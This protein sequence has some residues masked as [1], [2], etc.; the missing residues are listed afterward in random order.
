MLKDFCIGN[1]RLQVEELITLGV[2]TLG[3]TYEAGLKDPW[4]CFDVRSKDGLGNI[5]F[6]A[7]NQGKDENNL[8]YLHDIFIV[9]MMRYDANEVVGTRG[10]IAHP[11]NSQ[12][13]FHL[14]RRVQ[15]NH[16]HQQQHSSSNFFS[17]HFYTNPFICPASPFTTLPPTSPPHF[18]CYHAPLS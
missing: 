7:P 11:R 1:L 15:H 10:S 9:R 14:K 3:E 8:I 13:T 5:C 6:G 18:W 17:I 2:F 4:I 12:Q 16:Q